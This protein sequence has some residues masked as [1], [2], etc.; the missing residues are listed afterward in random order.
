LLDTGVE[1]LTAR[2]KWKK[3]LGHVLAALAAGLLVALPLA[4]SVSFDVALDQT[5][6]RETAGQWVEDNIRPG[7]KIA[8]EH[9]SIPFDYDQYQVEDIL[10]ISDHDLSWYQEEGFEVAIV[11]D[12]IW[13]V[14]RRQ[15]EFY[16]DQV[17]AYDALS[18]NSSLLAEFVPQPAGITVAGYPTVEI[19][20]FAPVRI[21]GIPK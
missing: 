15:P 5:D 10:R 6:H 11:S 16:A 18:T 9:Y 14:L 17:A 13:E 4:A 12:G 2:F 21:Y 20:H 1:W 19:Y 3:R 7:S 8:I